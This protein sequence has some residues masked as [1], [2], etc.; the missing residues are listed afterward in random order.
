MQEIENAFLASGGEFVQKKVG[1]IFQ[2]ETGSLVGTEKLTN[3]EIRRI[4]AKNENNGIIGSFNTLNVEEARHFENFITVNFFGKAFYHPYQASV[5]MKVH[6]L[7][8]KNHI[9][10]KYTGLYL[11]ALL[12]KRFSENYSYGSQLSSSKLKQHDFYIELPYQNNEIAFDY[13]ERF[14]QE[15]RAERAQE[16]RAFLKLSNLTNVNLSKDEENALAQLSDSLNWKMFNLKELFG[17]ATRG[18][19]LKSD[20]RI[21]GSLPFVT[22]GEAS[23]GISA[24]IGNSVDVFKSN[25]VTIDMFGSAKYR[26]YEYGADDHI[27]VVHTDKIA[28]HAVLFATAA[29]HKVA[30]AGQFSYSRNFYAKDADE[31]NIML[32]EKDGEPD[33]EFMALIGRAIE[34]CVIADVV[35]FNE[36][37]MAAYE[38][39]IYS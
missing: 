18:K 10:N 4:S 5:E 16:L 19:R 2:I 1:D 29:M 8:M 11:T 26:N 37:E 24:F 21:S 36:R 39:V 32:P 30:N 33:W 28:K 23:T 34:K 14:V 3:G 22:A 20:D 13:M 9:F 6:V 7:K 17:S 35:A 12:D 38:Q 25:T 31:L 15:L 27:A